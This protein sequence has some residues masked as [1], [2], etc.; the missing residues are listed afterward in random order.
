MQ[1]SKQQIA[2]SFSLGNFESTFPYLSNEIK[3]NIVG[4][5][6]IEGKDALVQHCEQVA[7]YFNSV[8]T[9]FT[10]IHVITDKEMVCA[11]GTAEF[12]RDGKRVNFVSACDVYQFNAEGMIQEITSYC[13]AD[14]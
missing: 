10:T 8:S 4:E 3:W 2:E 9:E 6:K 5:Q 13:I 12:K 7:S 11:T 14:K 1:I